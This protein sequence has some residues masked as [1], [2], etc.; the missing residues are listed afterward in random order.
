MRVTQ[1]A[2]VLAS[3][4]SSADSLSNNQTKQ[5]NQV[6]TSSSTKAVDSNTSTDET[7]KQSDQLTS[8]RETYGLATLENMSDEEYA[9]FERATANMSPT[10][11]MRAAQSLHL[12]AKSYQQAQSN[13][14]GGGLVNYM[15]GNTDFFTQNTNVLEEGIRVLNQMNDGSSK[16]MSN[17]LM[18]YKGALASNGLNLTA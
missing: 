15:N 3:V 17:F 8:K 14:N 16:A 4:T 7:Q 10:E 9:A 11:K 2:S 6:S 12:V 5:K 18:R 13:I 1:D